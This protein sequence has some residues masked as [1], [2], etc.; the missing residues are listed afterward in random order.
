MIVRA[1]EGVPAQMKKAAENLR[2]KV[3]LG[4]ESL[5]NPQQEPG[6]HTVHD[7]AFLFLLSLFL[8]SILGLP[9]L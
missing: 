9:L 1:Q 3:A 2:A 6:S 4:L 7:P 5:S 8:M